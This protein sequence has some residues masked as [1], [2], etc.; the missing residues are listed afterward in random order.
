MILDKNA[1]ENE[2]QYTWRICS[3]KDNGVLDMQWSEVAEILNENLRDEEDYQTESAYR[4]KYQMAK[5]MYEDVFSQ[6]KDEEENTG[7][8]SEELREMQK[9]RMK[10]QTEKLE[11]NRWLREQSR[12]ELIAE[13]ICDAV[14]ELP[15]MILP[16][17]KIK[18]DTSGKTVGLL[19]FG[20]EHFGTEFQILGLR[21]ETLNEYNPEICTY[22]I[23]KMLEEAKKIIKKNNLSEVHV[24]CMGDE[25]DGI[26]R[27]SQLM[28]LR[29]GVVEGSVMYAGILSEFLN[30]LSDVA[31]IKFQMVAGNHTELR[32]LG[33]PKGTFKDDNMDL[34]IR[35]I[36][37]ERLA[38]NPRFEFVENPSGYIYDDIFGYK[39]LGIHGDTKSL[40]QDLKSFS[41]IY[42]V[43]INY[44]IAGHKH[45]SQ[46]EDVGVDCEC[47]SI[48]S[49]IGID[50][51]A[52]SIKKTSN[53]GAKFFIIEDGVGKNV[54]YTIKLN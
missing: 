2:S 47:I 37:K 16:Q 43:K 23:A 28:K 19:C 15:D 6:M 3:A 11:Y 46:Q 53:A 14:R 5:K 8:F 12:D 36:V 54:E 21:G 40:E 17:N 50:D 26:L 52:M 35:T 41:N 4:K 9:E 20:D 49:V 25:S 31:E 18:T 34:V 22:R 10:L 32:M 13:K 48:P 39:F 24:Y 38:S 29:Y 45:H 51:Y 27:V 7:R 42:D 30:G 1:D 33:Q 44:L